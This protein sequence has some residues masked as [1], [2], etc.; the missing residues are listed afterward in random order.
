[1]AQQPPLGQGVLSIEA[2]R[3]HSGTPQSVALLWTS[4]QPD[5]GTSTWQHTTLTTNIYVPRGM[6]SRN[7]S[8]RAT[9]DP[10]LRQRGH[11]DRILNIQTS[12]FLIYER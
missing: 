1:M 5:A 6:Q 2:S 7:P 12:S 3:S 4:D 8:K 10:R 9:V 11:L